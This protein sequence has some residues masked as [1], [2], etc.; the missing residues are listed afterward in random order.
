MG[1]LLM[2]CGVGVLVNMISLLGGIDLI[3][4]TLASS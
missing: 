1:T 3:S 2:I 4:D